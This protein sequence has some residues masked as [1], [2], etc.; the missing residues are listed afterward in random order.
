MKRIKENTNVWLIMRPFEM[1]DAKTIIPNGLSIRSGKRAPMARYFG[2]M[3]VF[4][5][6]AKY[7]NMK[8]MPSVIP[9]WPKRSMT[10]QNNY[11]IIYKN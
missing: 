6:V 2:S 11:F 5:R 3:I 1:V 8:N 7:E 4:N 10:R 9:I